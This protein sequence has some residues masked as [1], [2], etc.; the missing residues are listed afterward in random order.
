MQLKKDAIPQNKK[1]MEKT[2]IIGTSEDKRKPMKTM[3][4]SAYVL[5]ML[6][7][8]ILFYVIGYGYCKGRDAAK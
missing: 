2:I 6:S 8:G 4:V 1:I 3:P 7:V 5:S